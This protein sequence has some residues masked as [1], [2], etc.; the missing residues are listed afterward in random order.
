MELFL[1]FFFSISS[2]SNMETR[3][4]T[5]EASVAL[6]LEYILHLYRF[7]TICILRLLDANLRRRVRTRREMPVK[8]ST[9]IDRMPMQVRHMHRLVGITDFDCLDNLRMDRNTFGG[10]CQLLKHVGGLKDG[11]F[12]LVEEQIAMFLEIL[13]HHR[14]HRIV[15]FDFWRSGQTVSNYVHRVLR[16]ILKLNA[17]VTVKPDPVTTDSVDPRWKWF[18]VTLYMASLFVSKTSTT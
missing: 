15:K 14:K 5:V 8:P 4:E 13:A 2:F 1:S 16:S 10:L 6:I 12:V 11:R 9:L 7:E 17:L 3:T 18:K